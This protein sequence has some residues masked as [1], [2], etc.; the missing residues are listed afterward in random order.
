VVVSSR[1]GISVINMV[2]FFAGWV[3]GRHFSRRRLLR[4]DR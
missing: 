1:D 3:Y 2:V 4:P